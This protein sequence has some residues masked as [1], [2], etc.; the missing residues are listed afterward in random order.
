MTRSL[1]LI[2]LIFIS[3]S[4][5]SQKIPLINSGEVI[6]KGKELYDS[7]K[8]ADA[9]KVFNTVSERDTNYVYMLYESALVYIADKNYDKALEICDKALIHP[10]RFQPDLLRV[11]AM[12]T[13]KKGEVEKSIAL[14]KKALEKYPA[15]YNILYSMGITYY[16]SKAYE[17][18]AE[19]FFKVLYLNPFHS[20]SHLNLG[21][22]SVG[23]GRKTHAMLSLGMYLC[24]ANLDNDHLVMLNNFLD[25]QV[26]DE[27]TLP[28]FGT[29]A[30]EKLDQI[31]K[32][33][34]AID[35]NFKSQ[36][37][38]DA[39]VVKQYEMFFEQLGTIN[40]GTD[41]PWVKFYKPIYNKIK[42]QQ[43]VAPFIYHILSSTSNEA[44]KK[45]RSKNEKSLGVFFEAVKSH[46]RKYREHLDPNV[47]GFVSLGYTKPVMAWFDEANNLD[48]LGE[49]IGE[50][51][52]GR[53]ILFFDNKELFGE[54]DFNDKGEKK[55][56]WKFYNNDGML[57]SIEN[58]DTDEVT[59]YFRNGAKREHYF[60]KDDKL[61]GEV[62]LYYTCGALKEKLIY[63]SGNREGKGQAYFASGK[64][65][66]TYEYH[67]NKGTGEFVTYYA[68]GNIF[69]KTNYKDDKLT[70]RYLTLYPDGKTKI[71]GEYLNDAPIGT[72]KY[73]FSNGKVDKTGNFLI[74][75]ATGEWSYYDVDGTLIEK[76]IFDAEGRYQGENSIY[77]NGKLQTVY[78]YKKDVIIKVASY[79]SEG[80]EIFK[81]GGNDG[82]Y[83]V[84]TYYLTGELKSE[85]NYKKGKVQGKWRYY[86]RNGK[87]RSEYNYEDG[88]AQG[89]ATQYFESGAKKKNYEYKDDELNGYFQEF[90]QHGQVK[91][92]GWF[93]A[94]ARQQQWLTYYL[95]GTIETD[96]YYLS[97]EFYGKCFNYASD[98]KLYSFSTYDTYGLVDM[99]FYD[100][101]GKVMTVNKVG[102]DVSTTNEKYVSNKGPRS[103]YQMLC[104]SYVGKFARWYPDGSLFYS[105]TFE[106]GEKEGSYVSNF[107]NGKKHIEGIYLNDE[108]KGWWK[109]Y[110]DNGQLNR[111]GK[112]E[113]GKRDSIWTFYTPHGK[114]SSIIPYKTDEK[115]G[116]AQYFSPEGV[117]ILEK[118]FDEGD[119]ISYRIA[120]ASG[121]WGDWIKFTGNQS[122]IVKYANGS[123]AYEEEFKDG[124][125]H[126]A[127][128]TYFQNGKLFD[129]YHY[130]KG[131][132][133]GPY[134]I[135]YANGKL[136]Q[137]GVYT[138][139]ELEGLQESYNE[140]GSLSKTELYKMGDQNGKSVIYTKGV[141]SK[142]ITFRDD[143]PEE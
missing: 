16:N 142:E 68:N 101:Q 121:S 66:N 40:E 11:Q 130:D 38:V 128:K 26:T 37:P 122:I 89:A 63:Q 90:Y 107:A 133:E 109:W 94:G 32:A 3:V 35:K 120:N 143:L 8:Y 24:I 7:G 125:R 76:R 65:K 36:V 4:C 99:T 49:K 28:V 72:W 23:Q 21:R 140:D 57:K 53:W 98:G 34:I 31:I 78:T 81:C 69:N 71:E 5:F 6:A 139:D 42:E 88:L 9:V 27:G 73:Y 30:P 85:G 110:Y 33:K 112:Y 18:A 106:S 74:G 123:S 62:E 12:A 56:I 22:I 115:H 14:F 10:E 103:K 44:V 84:K 61:N 91:Q 93:Q 19:T 82:S 95:D 132:Y 25:N 116:V 17:Q 134:T 127:K 67:E 39:V 86:F 29:N 114:V 138:H 50:I 59:L 55:G 13:D 117:A 54:G 137:K 46:L 52:K 43:L 75:I 113:E 2:V 100:L 45:W 79:N 136:M 105:Y 131:A 118:L 58:Y 124:L 60:S 47:Y 77:H 1:S 70:G 104:G 87:L 64:V 135:Y 15:D 102:K 80:K 51:R 129:E 141:K 92:E 97:D 108:E 126:G 111:E 96:Y 119:I 48:A 83:A 20:G 41:D